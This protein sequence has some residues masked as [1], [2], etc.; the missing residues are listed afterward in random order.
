MN[1]YKNKSQKQRQ[2]AVNATSAGKLS[3]K[4]H[5]LSWSGIKSFCMENSLILQILT[6]KHFGSFAAQNAK[7]CK[8][9]F[10]HLNNFVIILSKFMH[11]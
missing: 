9:E 3:L 7:V 6:S 1:V 11:A 4:I 10:S 2:I 5:E 8:C